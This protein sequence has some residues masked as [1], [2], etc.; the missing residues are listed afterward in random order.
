MKSLLVVVLIYVVVRYIW[1]QAKLSEMAQT[2]DEH[3]VSMDLFRLV[4]QCFDKQIEEAP[5][6]KLSRDYCYRAEMSI[7]SWGAKISV[8]YYR[9]KENGDISYLD[10]DERLAEFFFHSEGYE[11]ISNDQVAALDRVLMKKIK[12]YYKGRPELS[13]KSYRIKEGKRAFSI[14]YI[15]LSDLCCKL[16][17]I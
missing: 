10:R 5:K 7:S 4:T 12:E 8:R 3:S 6:K 13:V 11:D 16:K 15:D 1:K 2:W 17:K 9:R 14:I